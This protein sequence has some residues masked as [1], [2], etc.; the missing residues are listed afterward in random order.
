MKKITEKVKREI[1]YLQPFLRKDATFLEIGPGDCSLSFEVTK[2][3]KKVYAVDVSDVITSN[4]EKTP[5]NFQLILSDGCSVPVG[6]NSIDL[7][8]SNQLMEHLHPEAF[9]S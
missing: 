1:R 9:T 6:A 4:L 3:V 2:S 7:V 8:Y 5:Q